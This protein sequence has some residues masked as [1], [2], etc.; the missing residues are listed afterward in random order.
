MCHGSYR[1]MMLTIEFRVHKVIGAGD[2][3]ERIDQPFHEIPGTAH[4]VALALRRRRIAANEFHD[5]AEDRFQA[6]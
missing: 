6:A 4:V 1:G 5:V 2:G 3:K